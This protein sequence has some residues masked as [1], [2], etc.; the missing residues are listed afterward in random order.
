MNKADYLH[1]ARIIQS[2]S[3]ESLKLTDAFIDESTLALVKQREMHRYYKCPNQCKDYYASRSL[4]EN[5]N[6]A[7]ELS[8]ILHC[9]GCDSIW[10]IRDDRP[11]IEAIITEEE[12]KFNKLLSH[13]QV[14]DS[15]DA[16]TAFDLWSSKGVPIE[17]L[18]VK[19]DNPDELQAMIENF[20]KRS[21]E[22]SKF[23]DRPI[24]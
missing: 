2:N 15:I 3:E 17:F 23:K 4:I 8:K 19:C 7:F 6:H 14:D 5:E 13:C 9:Y 20:K 18:E 12:V 22:K 21:R 10:I 1:N 24:F 16:K 11:S